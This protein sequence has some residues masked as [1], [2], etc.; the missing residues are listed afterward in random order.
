MDS[1]EG[2]IGVVSGDGRLNL[3]LALYFEEKPKKVYALNI[4]TEGYHFTL[5]HEV[6]LSI[7]P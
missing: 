2:G 4:K 5:T 6:K 7:D 1:R 3:A